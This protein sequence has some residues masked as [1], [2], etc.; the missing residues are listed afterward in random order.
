MEKIEF[1]K[2]NF[3]RGLNLHILV[4]CLGEEKLKELIIQNS[5]RSRLERRIVLPSNKCLKKIVFH[6]LY[7]K[8]KGDLNK[9]IIEL[10]NGFKTQKELDLSKKKIIEMWRQ[11]EKE[12][13]QEK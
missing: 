13:K 11:R 4:D 12:I 8:H 1:Q 2:L 10:R 6:H 5:H 3:P 7:K 9:I